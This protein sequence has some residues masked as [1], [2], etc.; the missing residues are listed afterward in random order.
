V[1]ISKD[2]LRSQPLL[3]L[4][5]DELLAQVMAHSRYMNVP[6]RT[7]LMM[8]GAGDDWLGSC[9]T[10]IQVVDM[11]HNGREV[12]LNIIRPG[13]FF[14]ELSCIDRRPRSATLVAMTPC[15]LIQVPARSHGSCF[16]APPRSPRR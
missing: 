9:S 13:S 2:L 1:Q 15:H 7:M 10:A 14:G 11:L 6:K 4:L 16:S 8:K 12:G 5:D 3:K